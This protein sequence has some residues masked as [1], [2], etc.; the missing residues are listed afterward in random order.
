[1][2]VRSCFAGLFL[3]AT[4]AVSLPASG[5]EIAPEGK[6]RVLPDG[7]V[8]VGEG[9]VKTFVNFINN[10]S[11]LISFI[12]A[13]GK[14]KGAVVTCPQLKEMPDLSGKAREDFTNTLHRDLLKN[15]QVVDLIAARIEPFPLIYVAEGRTNILGAVVKEAV[16]QLDE[17]IILARMICGSRLYA[18][19]NI[20]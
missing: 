11:L 16:T 10:D 8:L 20:N 1:M 12:V 2:T 14:E 5:Q 7:R 19:L 13:G 3:A 15:P 18:P 6:I 17:G 9:V 4:C